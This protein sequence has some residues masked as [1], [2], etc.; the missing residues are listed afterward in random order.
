MM[1]LDIKKSLHGSNGNM[2]LEVNIDIKQGEFV[3]I[4]GE[5]GSG[6]TTLLRVLAGLEKAEANIEVEGIL[7]KDVPCQKRD[8]GFVF[9]DYALF[10]NMTV[11]QNLLFVKDD[12]DLATKLLEMTALVSLKKRNVQ[13]LSGGQKQ[14]VALCRAIMKK[15]KLLLLDEP[16]SALDAQMRSKLQQDIK[17]LHKIFKMT[18]IMVS[19][20]PTEVYALADRVLVLEQGKVTQ[21]GLVDEVLHSNNLQNE[22]EVLKLKKVSEKTIAT[23]FLSGRLMEIEVEENVKVFDKIN[24]KLSAKSSTQF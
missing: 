18:T 19:H 6:K 14:R 21:D 23:I 24:I 4:M 13:T 8:I 3:V 5:S 20:E 1:H 12:Q 7:W 10:D 15:P 11:E 9:Q 16:L 22:V 17:Q 2:E